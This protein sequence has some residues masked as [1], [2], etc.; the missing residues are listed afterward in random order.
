MDRATCDSTIIGQTKIDNLV[1]L[2]HNV[3]IGENC[4]LVSMVGIAGSTGLVIVVIA[5][6]AGAVGHIQIGSGS[7]ILAGPW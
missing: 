6:Q 7:R 4:L 3:V 5:G 1:Q 2:G